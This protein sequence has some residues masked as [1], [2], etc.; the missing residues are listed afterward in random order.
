MSAKRLELYRRARTIGEFFGP[1]P[2]N[3]ARARADL[4]NDLKKQLGSTP[5]LGPRDSKRVEL[6]HAGRA[7]AVLAAS[8]RGQLN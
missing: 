5:G 7:R 1:Y 8:A 6:E 3:E 2:G 4:T